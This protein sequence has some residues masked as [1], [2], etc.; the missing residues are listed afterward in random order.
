M[1]AGMARRML[2]DWSMH[3]TLAS[4]AVAAALASG[5][6]GTTSGTVG[7]SSGYYAQPDLA[8][9]AP[10]VSVIADYNEPI[11]YSDGFYWRNYNN[12]WY[13][14]GY[15]TGGW[16]SAAAPYG[17]VNIRTPGAYVRYRPNGYVRGGG[18]YGPRGY[19]NRGGGFR[20]NGPVVRDHRANPGRSTYRP[21][22]QSG[23]YRG[24]GNGTVIRGTSGP[25]RPPMR[26]GPRGGGARRR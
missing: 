18:Y 5:C 9:V 17:I 25:A 7:Y 1:L 2:H 14:S 4:V 16:V 22:V 8:Y 26:S 15:Y 6:Y 11:F 20:N 19:V 23:G 10:G 13:R 24:R 12:S 3:L 21:P